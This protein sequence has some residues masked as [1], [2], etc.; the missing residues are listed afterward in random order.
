MK[1]LDESYFASCHVCTLG[2]C[3]CHHEHC[4]LPTA[5][6]SA[7]GAFKAC[8]AGDDGGATPGDAEE[9]PGRQDVEA[10]TMYRLLVYGE[11]IKQ[12]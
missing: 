10:P 4:P 2:A 7:D 6:A 12:S 3:R 11:S 1:S 8:G 9:A 5:A